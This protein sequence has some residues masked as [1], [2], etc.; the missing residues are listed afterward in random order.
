MRGVRIRKEHNQ[1]TEICREF[2]TQ[3]CLQ[4]RK[5]SS[6]DKQRKKVGGREKERD[7]ACEIYV[8]NP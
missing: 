7:N 4:D 2:P 5:K 1:G 6:I 8:E 3:K